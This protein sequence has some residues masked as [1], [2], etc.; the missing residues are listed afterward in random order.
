MKYIFF[1]LSFLFCLESVNAQ[2]VEGFKKGQFSI[3]SNLLSWVILTP[4][5]GIEYQIND[6]IGLLL[7]GSFS[8]WYFKNKSKDHYWR[9]WHFNPKIRS[10]LNKSRNA[11]VGL[12]FDLGEYNLSNQQEEF[13]GGGVAFGKQYYFS[14]NTLIDLG[15]TLGYLKLND[16]KSYYEK[17]EIHYLRTDK[18]DKN[19]WGPTQVSISLI[20]KLNNISR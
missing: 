2:E 12:Q 1:G 20:R 17:E 6:R 18:P 19:Y 3:R 7:D 15:L 9:L 4:N 14:K 8:Y 11:Y 16:R 5:I 10:Y 13:K